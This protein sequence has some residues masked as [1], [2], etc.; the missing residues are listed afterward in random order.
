MDLA[1]WI[2]FMDEPV[3][4]DL[5][6]YTERK[7]DFNLRNIEIIQSNL[8]YNLENEENPLMK[9]KILEV[10]FKGDVLKLRANNYGMIDTFLKNNMGIFNNKS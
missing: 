1:K 8:K 3:I 5:L 6:F 4:K 10:Y 9:A 7:V 2:Q